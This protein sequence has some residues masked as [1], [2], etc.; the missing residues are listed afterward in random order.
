MVRT[1]A[2]TDV[3]HAENSYGHAAYIES[4]RKRKKRKMDAAKSNA[5]N[6]GIVSTTADT[7]SPRTTRTPTRT[8]RLQAQSEN[9]LASPPSAT[10]TATP[11][12]RNSKRLLGRASATTMRKP[13]CSDFGSLRHF[14][15]KGGERYFF[16]SA[17]DLWDALPPDA[18]KKVSMD[19]LKFGCK[20]NHTY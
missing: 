20:A 10:R 19:S 9:A 7:R 4:A 17:C 12:S 15:F 5:T 3:V 13:R 11:P 2:G 1:R 16:C 8:T 18:S 14:A 6:A